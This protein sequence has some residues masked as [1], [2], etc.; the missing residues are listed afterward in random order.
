MYI[1]MCVN[2]CYQSLSSRLFITG[3]TVD[4]AGE[5]QIFNLFSLQCMVQLSR[6]KEVIFDR[7]PGS[8]EHDILQAFDGFQSCQL[9][10][11]R[12]TAGEAVYIILIT[13]HTFGLQE[14][15]VRFLIGKGNNLGLYTRA[16]TRTDTLDLSV[17]KG[18]ICKSCTQCVMRLCIGI[19]DPTRHLFEFP[20]HAIQ[21]AE[22]M[23]IVIS[24]LTNEF[25]EMD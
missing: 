20:L 15:L 21:I 16:I 5:K 18:R 4:L 2:A 25:I 19:S 14:D 17:E 24:V 22:L 8:V 9:Y 13:I 3:C 1:D 10:L 6:I 12:Q 23:P 11:P 7:V